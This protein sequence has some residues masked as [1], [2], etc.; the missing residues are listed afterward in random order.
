MKLLTLYDEVLRSLLQSYTAK[1]QSRKKAKNLRPASEKQ[2]KKE[3]TQTLDS[4]SF[5]EF[6]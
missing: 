5:G 3:F 4:S 2:D 1:T 6:K